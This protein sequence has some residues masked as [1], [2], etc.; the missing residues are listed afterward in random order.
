MDGSYEGGQGVDVWW[1]RGPGLINIR[2]KALGRRVGVLK[3]KEQINKEEGYSGKWK[4]GEQEMCVLDT[5]FRDK[6]TKVGPRKRGKK[7]L[8]M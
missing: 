6:R 4:D 5:K 2:L 8:W 7:M 1:G 3:K